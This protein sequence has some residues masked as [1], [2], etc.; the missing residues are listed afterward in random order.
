MR[1]FFTVVLVTFVLIGT[2]AAQ[3]ARRRAVKKA[4]AAGASTY[5]VSTISFDF[6][7]SAR[8]QDLYFYSDGMIPGKRKLRGRADDSLKTPEDV[9]KRMWKYRGTFR[10]SIA[11]TEGVPS[12]LWFGSQRMEFHLQKG[13]EGIVIVGDTYDNDF[14]R[15]VPPEMRAITKNRN[16]QFVTR[17]DIPLTRQH[18][19]FANGTIVVFDVSGEGEGVWNLE[20]FGEDCGPQDLLRYLLLRYDDRPKSFAVPLLS[21]GRLFPLVAEI[22]DREIVHFLDGLRKNVGNGL[23]A[24]KLRIALEQ[25]AMMSSITTA[26]PTAGADWTNPSPLTQFDW[27]AYAKMARTANLP[28]EIRSYAATRTLAVGRDSSV[29]DHFLIEIDR[30]RIPFDESKAPGFLATMKEELR[31]RDPTILTALSGFVAMLT[32]FMV[33]VVKKLTN[34]WLLG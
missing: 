10:T 31:H 13:P 30:G 15:Q 20:P 24:E 16:V 19:S 32:L 8:D 7:E 28:D 26:I 27:I 18:G 25:A 12:S 2:V 17:D 33:I 34:R 29:R 6:W 1:S 3:S 21:L 9:E 23:P 22:P 11:A 5:V 4:E 14:R